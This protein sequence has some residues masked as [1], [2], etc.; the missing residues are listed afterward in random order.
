MADINK[1]LGMPEQSCPYIDDI[2]EWVDPQRRFNGDDAF[3]LTTEDIIE[4]LEKIR[5]INH[6]L[7]SQLV[8]LI[9]ENEKL[10]YENLKLKVASNMENNL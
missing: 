2:I 4:Y 1:L 10:K 6:G 8:S 3:E 5:E 7:R 9:N